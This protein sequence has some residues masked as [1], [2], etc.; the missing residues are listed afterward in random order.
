MTLL[1]LINQIEDY[2]SQ[3]PTINTI[4]REN[5]FDL[6]KVPDTKYG[7]FVWTQGQHSGTTTN[8]IQQFRFSFF[9][10]DRLTFDKSNQQEIQS[11]GIET[12]KNIVR[13]LAEDLDINSWTID[14]FT[15][16]FTDECAGAYL[17][18]TIGVPEDYVCGEIYGNF[19]LDSNGWKVVDVDGAYILVRQ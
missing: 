1:Q 2:A 5:V 17:T 9:Y 6:N 12:L 3:C 4:V 18:L 8:D 11:V 14:T 16:R 10:V 7:A 15:Q 13:L 19:L